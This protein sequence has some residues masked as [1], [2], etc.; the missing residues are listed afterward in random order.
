[1]VNTAR[2]RTTPG[3]V[4]CGSSWPQIWL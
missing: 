1:M 3:N 2:H 4:S